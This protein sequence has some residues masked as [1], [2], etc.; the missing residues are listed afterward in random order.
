[1][2]P[3]NILALLATVSPLIA[4][5]VPIT[6]T[7]LLAD[8][9]S[10]RESDLLTGDWG[11]VRTS[12]EESGMTYFAYY[13]GI[14]ASNVLGGIESEGN[15]SG[16]LFVGVEFDLETL[17][18]W[19]DTKFVLSGIDRHGQ[20]IDKGVGG[21]YSV[22]QNVGGQTAFLYNVTLEKLFFDESL[23]VKLGRMSATDDFVGSPYYGYSLNNAVN[24]QIRAALFDGVM[25]SYPFAVWGG[26]VKQQVNEEL[27]VMVGVFNQSPDIFDRGDQG[28]DFGLEDEDGLSIFTQVN[29]NPTFA[30]RPAHFFAG[31]NQ[32]VNYDI[33]R[34]NTTATRDEFTRLYAHADYQVYAETAGSDQ[35][36]VLFATLGYTPYDDVA[37][38][39]IQ[40]TFGAHYKG[41]FEGRDEDRTLFFAT[42][43][44]FSDEYAAEEALAGRSRPESEIVLELGHRFQ[45]TPSTYI[46]PDIQYII[47]PG[48]T[49]E[50]EDALVLGCQFGASF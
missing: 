43:G 42:Y 21:Q 32:V 50:I 30:N 36:L 44:Q 15:F 18:G 4:E 8:S 19:D 22:M 23:S 1:M 11:G 29:W 35:G 37:I 48:G 33:E 6:D 16:D 5:D 24:G 47:N 7:S 12:Q 17:F 2:R 25:S 38:I 10:W 14:L 3:K 49:G 9:S 34:F 27:S 46:Q 13:S 39:P 26:R 31:V 40:T 41:L 45:L 20:S 28:I